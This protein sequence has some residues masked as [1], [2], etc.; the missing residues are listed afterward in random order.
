MLHLIIQLLT[1][2]YCRRC[3]AYIGS[4][5]NGRGTDRSLLCTDCARS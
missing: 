3:G 2:Y 5:N 1:D 4:T